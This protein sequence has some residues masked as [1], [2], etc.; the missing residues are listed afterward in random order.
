MN[1]SAA[2][3][4][5]D[6]RG[7]LACPAGYRT[8]QAL[9][10]RKFGRDPRV[11]SISIQIVHR[12]QRR[13]ACRHPHRGRRAPGRAQVEKEGQ[14]RPSHVHGKGDVVFRGFQLTHQKVCVLDDG[15]LASDRWTFSV[16]FRP[17]SLYS[18]L[19][20]GEKGVIGCERRLRA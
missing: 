15:P 5:R 3:R 1:R 20:D 13:G 9:P 16:S 8:R 2:K 14:G 6:G 7:V 18:A 4:A 17:N 10:V 11:Y 12:G 19:P